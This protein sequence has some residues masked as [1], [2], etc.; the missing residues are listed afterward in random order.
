MDITVKEFIDKA[1]YCIE[2]LNDESK[3]VFLIGRHPWCG[4]YGSICPDGSIH[5]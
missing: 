2:Q 3:E 4:Y 5:T 1:K